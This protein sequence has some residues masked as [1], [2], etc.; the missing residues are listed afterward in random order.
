MKTVLILLIRAY[1]F[2]V[3]PLLPASCRFE[4]SCSAFALEALDRHGAI[5]GGALAVRRVLR[6]HPFHA[7]G[8]DP[9]P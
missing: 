6:C 1:R 5:R 4:P 2:C 8:H 9:V 7:G 3:S